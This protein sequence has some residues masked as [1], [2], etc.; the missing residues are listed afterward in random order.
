MF[1]QV[2]A[3]AMASIMAFFGFS[4]V[5]SQAD[6]VETEINQ[7]FVQVVDEASTQLTDLGF[8]VEDEDLTYEEKLEIVQGLYAKRDAGEIEE[9]GL[10]SSLMD[11]FEYEQV[12][13][14]NSYTAILDECGVG[15]PSIYIDLHPE[16]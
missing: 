3:F 8:D 10:L 9:G 6:V 14:I 11:W 1:K 12:N 16:Q 13:R 15:G 4:A 7:S 5:D 2:I